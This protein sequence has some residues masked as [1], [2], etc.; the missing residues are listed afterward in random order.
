[1]SASA[2]RA[3]GNA[4]FP[5]TGSSRER[6]GFAVRQAMLVA[7]EQH[8]W[9]G[10]FRVKEE[11]V[12]LSAQD[13]ETFDPEGR[14][15]MIQC[16]AILQ[17]LKLTLK[18]H[19]YFGRVELFPDLD[20]PRLAARVYPGRSGT[21]D[22]CESQLCLAMETGGNSR[23]LPVPVSN[24]VFDAFQRATTG[25]RSWLEIARCDE[26][27]Q[28]LA[29]LVRVRRTIQAT[30]IQVRNDTL[31]RS[32]D[33][34][35]KLVKLTGG[36]LQE[37]LARWRRPAPAINVQPAIVPGFELRERALSDGT[38]AV[39]KTKTD[40]KHGWLAAGQMLARMQLH[41][42]KLEVPCTPFIDVLRDPELRAELRAAIG[43]K[44]FT[45]VILSFAAGHIGMPAQPD[46]MYPATQTGTSP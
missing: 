8:W 13:S 18:R 38:F 11:S 20:Q 30:E 36:L 9:A 26:S 35:W 45:Q 4:G 17:Y 41:A 14:H 32:V 1:V 5:A 44:G 3:G 43:H 39:L 22:D 12:E 33:G 27:R 40:D 31:F 15:A 42:R 29:E 25:A 24:A 16:G 6:L 37:R 46:A 7:G 34:R 19:G 23:R 28:R 21:R 2:N 10:E